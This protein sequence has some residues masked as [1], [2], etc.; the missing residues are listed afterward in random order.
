MSSMVA[1]NGHLTHPG[2]GVAVAADVF[3]VEPL[4]I[5]AWLTSHEILGPLRSCDIRRS[6]GSVQRV[7]QLNDADGVWVMNSRI[8]SIHVMGSRS[9]AVRLVATEAKLIEGP[10]VAPVIVQ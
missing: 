4:L 10:G 2:I 6:S 8:A 7:R 3:Q 9:R 1:Q 5:E